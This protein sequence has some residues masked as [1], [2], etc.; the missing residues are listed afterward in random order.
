MSILV[1]HSFPK[2]MAQESVKLIFFE[3]ENYGGNYVE[4]SEG[5]NDLTKML[6]RGGS[7]II[8]QESAGRWR[9]FTE[10]TYQGAYAILEPGKR[11]KSL[12][13]MGLGNPVKSFRKE[14]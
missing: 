8:V 2:K 12:E 11:Y 6:P 3:R 7:S 1:G 13:E 10:V 9:A 5:S 4:L 14:F